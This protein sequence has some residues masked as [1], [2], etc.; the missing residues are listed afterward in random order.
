M[1]RTCRYHGRPSP[2]GDSGYACDCPHVQV[3][4]CYRPHPPAGC[5]YW[6]PLEPVWPPQVAAQRI[7]N[8][9][10]DAHDFPPPWPKVVL[11]LPGEDE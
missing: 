6:K 2:Y 3:A 10:C 8:E 1:S 9:W 7:V 5:D 11:V 4:S